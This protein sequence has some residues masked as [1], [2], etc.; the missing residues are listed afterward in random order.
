[1]APVSSRSSAPHRVLAA[2][3]GPTSGFACVSANSPSSI[4]TPRAMAAISFVAGGENRADTWN[5]GDFVGVLETLKR[6]DHQDQNHIIVDGIAIS[7]WHA[8]PHVLIEREP[9][10]EAALP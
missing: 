8:A 1:M 7:T 6:F 2:A 10:A 4:F 9:T 3:N 5:L